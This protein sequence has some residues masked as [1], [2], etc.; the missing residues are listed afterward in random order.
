[1]GNK[2]SK[3]ARQVSN[4]KKLNEIIS[5]YL[6]NEKM[7]GNRDHVNEGKISEE[8]LTRKC[9]YEES[10][11][12]AS[13][14]TLAAVNVADRINASYVI[15]KNKI[16]LDAY[17]TIMLVENEKL[18]REFNSNFFQ[19]F[20]QIKFIQKFINVNY[21]IDFDDRYHH[22]TKLFTSGKRNNELATD[23]QTNRNKTKREKIYDPEIKSEL[24]ANLSE[25]KIVETDIL[26]KNE[27]DNTLGS[28]V[29]PS[30]MF[31]KS[32]EEL[33]LQE[34]LNIET[35]RLRLNK[36]SGKNQEVKYENNQ[37]K[38]FLPY[39]TLYQREK[40]K[41]T[42]N[43]RK[44]SKDKIFDLTK[45]NLMRN[46]HLENNKN[47]N[48]FND[49]ALVDRNVKIKLNTQGKEDLKINRL[50][51]ISKKN[52]FTNSNLQRA[53]TARSEYSSKNNQDYLTKNTTQLMKH[54]SKS[55]NKITNS[56]GEGKEIFDA[57]RTNI[58]K[59]K[60]PPIASIRIDIRDLMKTENFDGM[61]SY[62]FDNYNSNYLP[63]RSLLN[64]CEIND[65]KNSN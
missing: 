54:R 65:Q 34:F 42:D 24:T 30:E 29:I 13:N 47:N 26:K 11:S 51:P 63:N 9:L 53:N 49:T 41:Q 15:S 58:D 16:N 43:H 6:T 33:S 46:K 19:E 57:Y 40:T 44:Q 18:S 56:I 64:V 2:Y 21:I 3:D 60:C 4:G 50:N 38:N 12:R 52:Q 14:I 39:N 20:D 27:Y 59:R 28:I 1:M 48:K 23:I 45:I 22:A 35:Q 7:Y 25:I 62:D 5:G 55:K 36:P 37:N 31:E 17:S 32:F 8:V 61:Q 10:Y